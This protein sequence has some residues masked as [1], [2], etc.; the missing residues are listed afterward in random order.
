MI[1]DFDQTSPLIKYKILA[2]C[3]TPRPIAWVSTIDQNGVVNLAPFSFFCPI[4]SDPVV[5][6]ICF[7]P[8]SDGSPKDTFKNI[9]ETKKA[10]ICMC[11]QKNLKSLQDSA[12]ELEYGISEAVK[13]NIDLEI[14]QNDYPPIIKN[15]QASF[16][17]EFYDILEI[18]K[19]SKTILL[20]STKCFIDNKIYTQDLRFTLQNVGRVGKYYQLPGSLIDPKNL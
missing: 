2:N 15:S 17:C 5:F 7:T 11:N 12:G 1:V 13:F 16:M 9:T 10:T 3:I 8:K 20:E 14:I 19:N 4:S 18:G 6:S